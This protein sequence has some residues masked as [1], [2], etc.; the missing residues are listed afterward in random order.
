MSNWIQ[1]FENFEDDPLL[2]EDEDDFEERTGLDSI[3][4]VID[5]SPQMLSSFEDEH[6]F[7]ETAISCVI[8]SLQNKIICSDSD[9]IG[10]LFYGTK[11][12]QNAFGHE[13]VYLLYDLDVPDVDRILKLETYQNNSDSFL[14]ELGTSEKYAFSDVLWTI[15][16][17]FSS[18]TKK[19]ASKRVFLVTNQDNPDQDDIKK[20]RSSK[21]RA[22]D[23]KD[24]E[25]SIDLFAMEDAQKPF[26]YDLFFKEI[27]SEEEGISKS[28][29][30]ISKF[31]QFEQKVRSKQVKKRTAFKIPFVIHEGLQISVLGYNLLIDQKKGLPVNLE[32][33]TNLQVK[34]TTKYMCEDTAQYLLPTDIKYFYEYG[35]ERV[36]FTKEELVGLK[37][38]GDPSLVLLGFKPFSALK[39]QQNI[40]HPSFIYPNEL[41]VAGSSSFFAH[42]LDRMLY[43]ERVA[44]CRLIPRK[45]SAPR[46]VAL[47]PD[48]GEKTEENVD[49]DAFYGFHV[50]YLPFADDRR[51]VI[52]FKLPEIS[53]QHIE[54]AKKIV[55]KVG[56]KKID[57]SYFF[58][59]SLQTHFANL[60]ALALKRSIKEDVEDKTLPK[61]ESI[62]QRAGELIKIHNEFCK[63]NLV[64]AEEEARP[65]KKKKIEV[66][67][68]ISDANFEILA[69]EGL[70]SSLTVPELSTFLKKIG[71]KAASKKKADVIEAIVKHF[72]F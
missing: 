44:I 59:P 53:E 56:L 27:I 37:N 29:S 46:L 45:N 36:V 28:V 24:L 26:N 23:L 61:T 4:W 63:S 69:K 15:S 68:D 18:V 16:S 39:M 12:K 14:D 64:E 66:S 49:S 71:K 2:E 67:H 19:L 51:S 25:I 8:K 70:L 34:T 30:A 50:I 52:D 5:C 17:V 1:N 9:L 40:K 58:N 13:N 62:H 43:L 55:K 20:L 48:N 60:Q 33:K 22:K 3:L 41:D 42:L 57:P 65:E 54:S 7:F 21:T 10:V 6:S 32:S 47:Y 38:F 31:E 35:G 11:K 72:G